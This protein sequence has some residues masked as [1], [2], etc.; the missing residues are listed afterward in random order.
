MKTREDLAREA[1]CLDLV[2]PRPGKDGRVA[3]GPVAEMPPL[4]FS[5]AST[6][7]NLTGGWKSV[8]PLYQDKPAPCQHGCP[9]GENIARYL[10][11]A[12]RGRY[13]EGWRLIME[14]NPLP[15]VMGRVCYHPCETACN[16]G[17]H[18]EPVA[19][20]AVERFLGD[21]GLSHGLTMDAP[22]TRR[23]EQIAVVGA[24]PA[25]LSAAYHL[26]RRGYP[27]TVFEAL[28]E[29]GGILR[30]GIPPYRLPRDILRREIARLEAHGVKICPGLAVGRDIPWKGLEKYQAILVA[31]GLPRSRRLLDIGNGVEGLHD[32][33]EFLRRVAEGV[34]SLE[35][36]RRVVIIGGG[37]VAIDVARSALRLGAAHAAVVCVE[38]F[39]V[40]PAH[41]EEVAAGA[42]EGVEFHCGFAV[43]RPAVADGRITGLSLR[44]VRFLGREPDGAVRFEPVGGSP[45]V[46]PVDTVIQTI[47]QEADLGFLPNSLAQTGR[48]EV[49][50]WGRL[51][52]SRVFAAGDVSSGAARVV[53][54]IGGGKRAASGIHRVLN[55]ESLEKSDSAALAIQIG[56]VNLL[57]F[58]PARQVPV[59]ELPGETRR[60]SMAEVIGGWDEG[61]VWTEAGR[62]FNCG[63][64]TGCDNCLVFCPDVAIRRNQTPDT[65]DVLDQYCK[66]CGICAREC[67]RHVIT[68][69]AAIP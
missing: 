46:L 5:T 50:G 51:R 40:M 31:T 21:Y 60:H 52:G 17:E 63:V 64:C 18:D 8:R 13:E 29:P 68:M 54:A 19:I 65:Y 7:V 27:V 10:R 28:P 43:E 53:D 23:R 57:Y 33:L 26:A 48:L 47:G 49:D 30:W 34:P 25:G 2:V 67:P 14:D 3:I 12:Q 61:Q 15:S 55:G 11:A 36:G 41:P 56:N 62:C 35:V 39:E 16:R 69:V 1:G 6:E 4:A 37:N 44:R 9:A 66:G 42:S 32:G 45:L 38:P 24:G 58:P 20:H 22:A 59:P